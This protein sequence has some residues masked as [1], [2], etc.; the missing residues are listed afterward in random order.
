[1]IQV[2]KQIDTTSWTA[3]DVGSS[4]VTAIT[5][6]TDASNVAIYNFYCDQQHSEAITTADKIIQEQLRNNRNQAQHTHNIW[7]GDFN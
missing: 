6:K 7:L 3:I 5:L 4:D 1:M 2:S